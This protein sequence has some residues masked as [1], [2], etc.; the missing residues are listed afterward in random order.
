MDLILTECLLNLRRNQTYSGWMSKDFISSTQSCAFTMIETIVLM[1]L[2]WADLA[3]RCGVVEASSSDTRISASLPIN[4]VETG[5]VFALHCQVWNL[6]ADTQA[7]QVFKTT[8]KQ[9]QQLS[10]NENVVPGV[11]ERIF[12]AVR[13]LGDGSIIYFLSIIDAKTEDEAVYECKV[14]SNFPK[15]TEVAVEK[16]PLQVTYFPSVSNPVCD[17]ID[18]SVVYEGETISLSCHSDPGN[19]AVNVAWKRTGSDK[20][21]DTKVR[22]DDNGR[23]HSV[24]ELTARSR[25][26]GAVFLCEISSSGFPGLKQTCHIGPVQIL[27]HPSRPFIPPPETTTVAVVKPKDSQD[28]II[29][30]HIEVPFNVQDCDDICAQLEES[31]VV[32]WVVGTIVA[33]ILALIFCIVCLVLLM[34]WCKQ[35]AD[36]FSTDYAQPIEDAEKIYVEVESKRDS[37]KMYMSLVKPFPESHLLQQVNSQ[38]M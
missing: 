18:S 17:D 13:H 22:T 27:K 14:V 24:A 1:V 33:A 37:G 29:G 2:F 26:N 19:P 8:D 5:A 12:M 34:K 38:K 30:G 32:Y 31:A 21:L 6:D 36:E 15:I 3:A 7:V 23:I 11:E 16:V 10:I 28:I 4:P 35:T 20:Y 9:S 25:D